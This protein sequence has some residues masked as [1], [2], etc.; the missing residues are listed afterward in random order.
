L[1]SGL[2][3]IPMTSL[4]QDWRT[5]QALYATLD[6]E[7]RFTFDPCPPLATFDGLAVA[8]GASTFVNPPFKGIAKWIEKGYAEAQK[9]RTVVFLIPSRTCTAWWHDYCLKA[10]EIRFIRGRIKYEGA[11]FNAPFPSCVVVFYGKPVGHGHDKTCL[12]CLY[13]NGS[14]APDCDCPKHTRAA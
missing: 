3:Q 12:T 9:G 10:D 6:G 13:D 14:H 4:R 7:F 11:K 2:K 1:G 5:P 8:W